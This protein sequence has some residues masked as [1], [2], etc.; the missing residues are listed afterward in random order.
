[1]NVD[2][3]IL[4]NV[5]DMDAETMREESKMEA[6]WRNEKNGM[7]ESKRMAIVF[8]CNPGISPVMHPIKEPRA[9]ISRIKSRSII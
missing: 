7:A 8:T 4:R 5:W 1:M 6:F 2:G 9:A 3:T